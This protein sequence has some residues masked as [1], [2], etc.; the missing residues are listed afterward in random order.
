MWRAAIT[1]PSSVHAVTSSS[2]L[3]NISLS[4]TRLWYLPTNAVCI[5]TPAKVELKVKFGMMKMW[6][7]MVSRTQGQEMFEFEVG[8]FVFVSSWIVYLDTVRKKSWKLLRLS[9]KIWLKK[10]K[11]H[12]AFKRWEL[13]VCS[14]QKNSP[15]IIFWV[16][17]KQTLF[18]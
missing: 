18:T 16:V 1:K 17:T 12:W 4:I 11:N 15:Y 6:I 5:P 14:F 10:I 9:N 7:R 8:W 2:S 13:N 3:G